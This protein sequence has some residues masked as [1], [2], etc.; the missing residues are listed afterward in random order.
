MD[1]LSSLA[2]LRAIE[3]DLA[4]RFPDRDIALAAGA[5]PIPYS[6]T[7]DV[8]IIRRWTKKWGFVDVTDISEIQSGDEITLVKIAKRQ[9]AGESISGVS[10]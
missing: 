2:L 10:L 9:P 6:S 3:L 7:K 1:E 5:V 8:H 4:K